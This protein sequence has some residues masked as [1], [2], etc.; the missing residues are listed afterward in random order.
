MAEYFFKFDENYKPTSKKAQ[1]IPSTR[2][3]NT[4]TLKY[5]IIQLLN[6]S[7][8]DIRIRRKKEKSHKV[9]QR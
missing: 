9:E 7:N 3:M 4:T 8:K 1:K 6:T 5:I 2:I